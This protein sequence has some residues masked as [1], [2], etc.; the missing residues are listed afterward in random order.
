MKR[1]ILPAP[2]DSRGMI[3][4]SGDDYHYLARVRR[5]GRGAVFEALLPSGEEVRVRVRAV[6]RSGLTGECLLGTDDGAALSPQPQ[7]WPPDMPRLVLF[8]AL[9]KGAKMDLI[10]RQ[11]AEGGIAEIVPFVSGYSVPRVRGGGPEDGKVARWRRIIKEAR[12]QSGSPVAT[13]IQVPGSVDTVLDYWKAL[14]SRHSGAL[15]LLFHLP[16]PE[17]PGGPGA[18]P[19]NQPLEQGSFH[20]Y[21]NTKPE[22][23]ALVIGP[24]GGFSPEEASR[25]A[26]ADF[27]SLVMGNTVLRVETAALYAAAAVRIILL[28][29]ASWTLKPR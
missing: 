22:I 19:L 20:G 29:R 10:V 9:P 11:A 25:F 26:A 27:K 4:L 14:R 23:V 6:T 21:L 12:Q 8:Q 18:P 28:E 1:F 2:P 5:L 24:E 3:R 13:A 15:G 7:P 17:G 16:V